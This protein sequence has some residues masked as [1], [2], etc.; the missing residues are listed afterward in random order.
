[1]EVSFKDLKVGETYGIK[2]D[3][4]RMNEKYIG[5]CMSMSQTKSSSI[6]KVK[7]NYIWNNE[8]KS[9]YNESMYYGEIG[10]HFYILK[11]KEKIQNAMEGR[12]YNKIMEK[13]IG[14][15]I[16]QNDIHGSV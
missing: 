2:Y 13:I 4:H 1:M 7:M 6:F 3:R 8:K 10:Y 15:A 9:M 11:Q 16:N 14:H 5:K 12:A